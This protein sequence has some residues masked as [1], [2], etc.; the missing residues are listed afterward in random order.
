[1]PNRSA[2]FLVAAS[3][4]VACSGGNEGAIPNPPVGVGTP[5]GPTSPNAA[6]IAGHTSITVQEHSKW[7]GTL[8]AAT[9]PDGDPVTFSIARQPARGYVTTNSNGN[10]TYWMWSSTSSSDQFTYSVSDG[11]GGQ[12]SWTVSVTIVLVN[13]PPQVEGLFANTVGEGIALL[14]GYGADGTFGPSLALQGDGRILVTGLCDVC[15]GVARLNTDGSRDTSFGQG[16]GILWVNRIIP[17]VGNLYDVTIDA[18]GG[19]V[20]S[21]SAGGSGPDSGHWN[22]LVMRLNPDGTPDR[23][24]AGGNGFTTLSSS[25][26]EAYGVGVL[27]D[28]RILAHG[29]RSPLLRFSPDGYL[30]TSFGG[31]DGIVTPDGNYV[32]Q[33]DGR[34]LVA[35]P[36]SPSDRSATLTRYNP[37][38]VTLDTGFGG[39][40]GIVETPFLGVI[41]VAERGFLQTFPGYIGMQ[42]DGR[43]LLA[44]CSRS[45][46]QLTR[47][48]PDGATD[49]GFGGGDGLAT[50][51]IGARGNCAGRIVVQPDGRILVATS[52]E[53]AG[54][55]SRFLADGTPDPGFGGGDGNVP[56]QHGVGDMALQPDGRILVGAPASINGYPAVYAMRFLPNGEQDLE[57]GRHDPLYEGHAFSRTIPAKTFVDPDGDSLV[58]TAT[59]A[60]GSALP[61]W[62]DFNATTLTFSGTPPTGAQDLH[63][64][65]T[66]TD[67]G[68][69]SVSGGF[70]VRILAP[71]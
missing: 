34:L 5:A 22:F 37:D 45:E 31:G 17:S 20:L 14:D 69:L 40:D 51:A 59:L 64:V 23:R 43:I 65:V 56:L 57:F 33:P 71:P 48:N 52:S 24:F 63:V 41:S 6:P 19:I 30:D 55:L 12:S 8:P 62:L 10:Y 25:L 18:D 49:M 3:L 70:G 29:I 67:P 26:G 42:A 47:F 66:A 16:A 27:P 35:G 2:L 39:G 28:G 50:L 38:G 13:D 46:M 44:G 11:R 54:S 60:G 32:A 9:D 15:P 36:R 21:G 58:V 1:M 7:Q 4:L 61:N 68:G 53:A